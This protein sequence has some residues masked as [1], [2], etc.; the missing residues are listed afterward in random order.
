MPYLAAEE[1][2]EASCLIYVIRLEDFLG[3]EPLARTWFRALR[4]LSMYIYSRLLARGS[5]GSGYTAGKG[6]VSSC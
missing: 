6:S 2:M 4:Y 3:D 1:S 5:R